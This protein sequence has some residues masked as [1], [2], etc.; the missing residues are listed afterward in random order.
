MADITLHIDEETTQEDRKGICD[1]LLNL[2]G[3]MTV[4]C[5]D[6]HGH[7]IVV[8]YDPTA[9]NPKDFVETAK[10]CGYHSE[11]IAML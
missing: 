5:R 3:V 1:K 11:L 6:K 8:E 7:L 4:S 9:I 2:P 10:Q